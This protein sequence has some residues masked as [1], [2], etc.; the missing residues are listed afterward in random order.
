MWVCGWGWQQQL[1]V[2]SRGLLPSWEEGVALSNVQTLQACLSLYNH[3][4]LCQGTWGTQRKAF[5]Y[6]A[7]QRGL[8]S[9]AQSNNTLWQGP[10]SPAATIITPAR[11][12]TRLSLFLRVTVQLAAWGGIF[13]FPQSLQ[14]GINNPLEAEEHF[15]PPASFIFGVLTP[16]SGNSGGGERDVWRSSES[17]RWL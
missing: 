13:Q 16:W 4:E 14:R 6:T 2:C 10:C 15:F 12:D 11:Q 8:S 1:C 3:L 17:W 5:N 7:R 9:A